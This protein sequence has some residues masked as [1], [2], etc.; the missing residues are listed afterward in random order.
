M[1]RAA[2]IGPRRAHNTSLCGGSLSSTMVA[3]SITSGQIP[4]ECLI[5]EPASGQFG[6]TARMRL[7]PTTHWV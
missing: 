5:E 7:L 1:I 3:S 4:M 2:P 6:S